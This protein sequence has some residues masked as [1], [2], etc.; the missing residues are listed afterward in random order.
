MPANADRC[1]TFGR[2]WEWT[3]APNVTP[4]ICLRVD[5]TGGTFYVKVWGARLSSAPGTAMTAK[6]FLGANVATAALE[7]TPLSS[8]TIRVTPAD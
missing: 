8:G 1:S 5:P 4:G 2:G 6:L 3:T 7:G